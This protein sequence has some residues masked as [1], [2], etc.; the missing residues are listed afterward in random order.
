MSHENLENLLFFL[1]S[2]ANIKPDWNEEGHVLYRKLKKWYTLEKELHDNNTKELNKT[3]AGIN[4]GRLG[5]NYNS[6]S[7]F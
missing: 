5:T 7:F 3:K 6:T 2:R 1:E 4:L